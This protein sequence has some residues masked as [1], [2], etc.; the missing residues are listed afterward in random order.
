MRYLVTGAAGFI[1]MHV[2]LKLL[3]KNNIVLGLDNLNNYYDKNLKLTRLKILKKFKKFKFIKTDI[4]DKKKI[5]ETFKKFYPSYVLHFAAQAGVRYSINNPDAYTDS[6]LLGFANVLEACRKIKIKHLV[7]ASSSSVY[8]GNTNFPF[9]ESENVDRPISFYAATKKSNELM[10]YS[11]SHLFKIPITCLR[12]FTVYGPW[13]RP[14][15]ALFLFTSA[16]RKNKPIKVFN[17]G[18]MFRDF[19]YVDDIVNAVYKITKKVPK[20]LKTLAPYKV[21][22]IGNNKPL[23]LKRYIKM[24]EKAVGKNGIKKYLPMQKGDLKY[25]HANISKIKSWINFKPKTNISTGINLFVK[26]HKEYYK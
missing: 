12:F 8:G 23:N 10:A 15:M 20:N 6:N 26:W 9:K 24:I 7:M 4:K 17:K 19:T 11:Y 13:G 21:F 3:K 2:C 1:G 5:L 16:I 18:N 25:T 14:D 22:N